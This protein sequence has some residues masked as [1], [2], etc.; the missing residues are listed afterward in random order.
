MH[1]TRSSS[2]IQKMKFSAGSSRILQAQIR[3][4]RTAKPPAGAFSLKQ[5]RHS[6]HRSWY[7]RLQK[8]RRLLR[9]SG[10][11]AASPP[12]KHRANCALAAE[13]I[14]NRRR[15]FDHLRRSGRLRR[16]LEGSKENGLEALLL[17]FNLQNFRRLPSSPFRPASRSPSLLAFSLAV[18][19]IATSLVVGKEEKKKKFSFLRC[20]FHGE[21]GMCLEV[22]MK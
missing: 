18:W 6:D 1:N 13:L 16:S 10:H 22:K 4:S 3:I 2:H 20:M 8:P 19:L 15:G 5:R 11:C 21:T 14:R 17:L 9:R 12:G 7:T